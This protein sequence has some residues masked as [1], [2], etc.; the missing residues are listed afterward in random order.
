MRN[1]SD[2]TDYPRP[3]LAVDT[4]T[5]TVADDVL[6]LVLV[7]DRHGRLLL[8]G[9][10]VHERE[11]LADAVLRSQ[12]Q[13]AGISGRE[14]QQ[15]KVFDDPDRDPR[16]WVVTVAHLDVVESEVVRAGI[17][18][19]RISL[20]PV[21]E[22][23]PGGSVVLPYDQPRVVAEAL[24]RVRADYADRPDPWGLLAEP[25]TLSDLRLLH[26]AVAGEEL[27]RDAFRRRMQPQL[28]P[29][30]QMTDG[31]RGRPSRLFV[32]RD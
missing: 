22:V 27:Q 12:A 11:R 2:L 3:S 18:A 21:V 23:G 7:R 4:A 5:F 32:H 25:F 20:V 30:G 17:A 10:F 16:G 29:T 8:P 14:P 13:K 6:H 31:R 26:E 19:G 24:A 15:L 1:P 9:T 28:V